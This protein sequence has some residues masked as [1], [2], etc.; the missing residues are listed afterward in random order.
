LSEFGTSATCRQLL[1][2]SVIEAK[3]DLPAEQP[4]F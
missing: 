2:K 4:D 1:T 3:A